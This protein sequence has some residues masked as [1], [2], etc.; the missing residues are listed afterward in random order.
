MYMAGLFLGYWVV[1]SGLQVLKDYRYLGAIAMV[2]AAVL[3]SRWCTRVD[4]DT[5]FMT[6]EFMAQIEYRKH[7]INAVLHPGRYIEYLLHLGPLGRDLFMT[8]LLVGLF[9]VRPWLGATA[10][11]A[12]VLINFVGGAIIF[13]RTRHQGVL[14]GFLMT[15]YWIAKATLCAN[16][17]LKHYTLRSS[18]YHLALLVFFV[19]FMVHNIFLSKNGFL[20]EA[21]VQK[22]SAMA[23]GNYIEANFQ[24]NRWIIIGEPDYKIQTL[25]YYTNNPI[26]LARE[27][28]F[29]SFVKYSTEFRTPMKLSELLQTAEELYVEHKIPIL[30]VL[31]VFGASEEN[32][33]VF[34]VMYRGTFEMSAEDIAEFKAKTLK[35]AE[36]NNS[37]GDED[38]Q[39]FV[40]AKRENL[41]GY[42]EKYMNL[43]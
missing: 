20:E 31:G 26:Y 11:V 7:I 33:K 4:V 17:N 29:A 22:S 21:R 35:L 2:V 9:A 10:L 28:K 40:Y 3:F 25:A 14:L 37:L 36:F 30:I 8:V 32:P 6:Q 18:V 13:P 23:L 27:K 41:D 1:S 34:D 16:P 15:S 19:P 12:V 43:R 5:V 39:L 24:M 42:R 38:Y